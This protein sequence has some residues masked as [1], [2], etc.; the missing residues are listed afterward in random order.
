MQGIE[1]KVHTNLT[2]RM[3]Y[4]RVLLQGAVEEADAQTSDILVKISEL[5]ELY[6][7][8]LLN[9][10]NLEKSIK[11]YR[12]YHNDLQRKVTVRLR[13]LRKKAREK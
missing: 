3:E 1:P 6:K 5:D 9:K 8:Y 10:R 12:E 13:E 4:F 11:N 2:S 7:D